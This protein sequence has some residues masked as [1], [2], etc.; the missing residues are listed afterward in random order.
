MGELSDQGDYMRVQPIPVL[1]LISAPK[2]SDS[3]ADEAVCNDMWIVCVCVCV[4]ACALLKIEVCM[5]TSDGLSA[6]SSLSAGHP[7]ITVK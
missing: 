5:C 2:S 4:C 7:L 3:H 1:H 6:C